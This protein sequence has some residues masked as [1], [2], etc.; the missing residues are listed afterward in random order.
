MVYEIEACFKDQILKDDY[1]F[2][3][4]FLFYISFN[5]YGAIIICCRFSQRTWQ[6]THG[7]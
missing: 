4:L 1:I 2:I 7:P 3:V 6:K 5:F